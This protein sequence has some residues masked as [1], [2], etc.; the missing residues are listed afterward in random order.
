MSGGFFTAGDDIGLD[1]I[2]IVASVVPE[3]SAVL[4]G[5]LV[6]VI[7]GLGAAWRRWNG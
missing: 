6:C 2:T 3:P 4:F 7:A 5:G 1:D